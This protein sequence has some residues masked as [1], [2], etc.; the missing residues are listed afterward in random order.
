MGHKKYLSVQYRLMATNDDF[1]YSKLQP[2]SVSSKPL[3]ERTSKS[4]PATPS[5]PKVNLGKIR[6]DKGEQSTR[7]N[8]NKSAPELVINLTWSQNKKSGFFAS[9]FSSN[10]GVDLDLGAYI[11]LVN[12]I[13][14]C[15]DALQFARGQ[16][17]PR[18]KL[19]RQGCFDSAPF[20]WHTGD[21]RQGGAGES[22]LVNPK[23][24]HFIDNIVVY[25]YIY[26]NDV[27]WSQTDAVVSIKAS[28][29]DEI[30][31]H[32]GNENIQGRFVVLAHIHFNN[33]QIHVERKM[34]GFDSLPEIDKYFGWGFSY[35]SGSK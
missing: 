5:A 24:A 13:Q 10:K 11:R 29:Q 1:D 28:G 9:L 23:F 33:G 21:D 19:T 3:H 15:V 12:G 31:V 26:D 16:G 32:L 27:I 7:I 30:E 2:S 8:L 35:S 17:G 6:L 20:L 34:L 25:T 22:I 4:E 18:H 14:L